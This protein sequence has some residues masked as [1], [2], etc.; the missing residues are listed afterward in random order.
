MFL[1]SR[2]GSLR[3]KATRRLLRFRVLAD[4]CTLPVT[5]EKDRLVAYLTI[6]ALN[7]WET[8]VRFFYLSCAVMHPRTESGN[9]VQVG[10][11][12]IPSVIDALEFSIRTLRPSLGK[13]PPWNR[14][15][16]PMW[17]EP[18][19]L[20][21]LAHAAGVSNERQI[22]AAFGYST[23]VF[24]HL[25]T[26]RNFYAHRNDSTAKKTEG[27]A[28]YYQL[29]PKLRPSELLCSKPIGRPQTLLSDWLD[30]LRNVIT[31]MCR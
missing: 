2:L 10:G 9:L 4:S 12:N 7:L 15:D 5:N 6:E 22:I 14:Q 20:V 18:S 21:K 29:S 25:P 24:H 27:V 23:A 31:L 30:D 19:T 16:E 26:V 3:E 13:R 1:S 8:F 11:V 17:R 28:R